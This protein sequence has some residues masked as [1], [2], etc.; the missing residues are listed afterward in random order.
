MEAWAKWTNDKLDYAAQ[1]LRWW[2]D[3]P[4]KGVTFLDWFGLMGNVTLWDNV[5]HN[6]YHQIEKLT[7]KADA[8]VSIESRGFIIGAIMSRALHL[9]MIPV[10]RPKKL[11][12]PIHTVIQKTEYGEDKLGLQVG[13]AKL[14]DVIIVDDVFATMGTIDCV[15]DLINQDGGKVIG[16]AGLADLQYVPHTVNSLRPSP[17]VVFNMPE[18][19]VVIPNYLNKP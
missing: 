9:P 17:L 4:I 15:M 14:R 10:R 2:P 7:P 8:I 6:L 19:G 1:E 3:F 16:I 12:G 5:T 18:P 11:P 13:A